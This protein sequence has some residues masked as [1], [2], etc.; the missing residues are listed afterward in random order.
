M[1][2][3]AELMALGEEFLVA[4]RAERVAH[5][6]SVGRHDDPYVEERLEGLIQASGA[7]AHKII[8]LQPETIEGAK[9]SAMAY[10]WCHTSFAAASL[11]PHGS[12]CTDMRALDR[13]MM[14]LTKDLVL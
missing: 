6:A 4:W 10:A 7:I 1:I 9:V 13:V 3:D 5:Q 11:G 14:F 2:A 12:P 8:E